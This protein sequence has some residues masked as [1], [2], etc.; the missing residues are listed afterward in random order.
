MGVSNTIQY[1]PD[2]VGYWGVEWEMFLLN[3]EGQYSP[4][5]YDFL[6]NAKN[7]YGHERWTYELSACQVE[8]RTEPSADLSAL[9]FD[10]RE[11]KKQAT[12]IGRIIGCKTVGIEV[13]D[14]TLSSDVYDDDERYRK[15]AKTIP[16]DRLRAACSVANVQVHIGCRD[17]HHAIEVNNK[18][19][20]HLEFLSD[21]GDNSNGNRLKLYKQMAKN[22]HPQIYRDPEH[23]DKVA[24]SQGF[25]QDLRNCWHMVRISRH[26]TVELRMFGNSD[27]VNHILCWVKVVDWLLK[28]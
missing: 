7:Y 1:N 22:W 4:K 15:L 16:Q 3:S 18:L 9:E 2:M 27:S 23:F 26:G 6:Q 25:D 21:I 5:A 13:A 8:C 17:I 11:A 12:H 28:H 10:L 24:E 19:V 20:P 14:D